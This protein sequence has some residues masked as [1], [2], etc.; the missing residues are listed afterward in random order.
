MAWASGEVPLV[1]VLV[2]LVV[3]WARADERDA[4]RIDRRA[5]ADGDADLVAYNAMLSRMAGRDP[6]QR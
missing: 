5:E 4:R 3:Q 1:V 6:A 2:A